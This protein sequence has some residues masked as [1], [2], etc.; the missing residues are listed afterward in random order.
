RFD[1]NMDIKRLLSIELNEFLKDVSPQYLRLVPYTLNE[2]NYLATFTP[3]SKVPNASM[4]DPSLIAFSHFLPTRLIGKYI[5]EDRRKIRLTRTIEL[6]LEYPSEYTRGLSESLDPEVP[7]S[8]SFREALLDFS[9]NEGIQKAF[10]GDT[11]SDIISW[12]K[13][14]K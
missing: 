11:L 4:P 1:F 14:L 8:N 7:V 13:S 2:S 9:K 10:T 3:K 6:A 5:I 12:Y